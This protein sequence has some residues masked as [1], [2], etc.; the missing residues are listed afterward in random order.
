M[1]WVKTF[2]KNHANKMAVVNL[3]L[4]K[5]TKILIMISHDINNFTKIDFKSIKQKKNYSRVRAR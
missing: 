2:L 3:Q 1:F 5:K 4:I